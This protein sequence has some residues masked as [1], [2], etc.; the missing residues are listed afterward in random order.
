MAYYGRHVCSRVSAS[1]LWSLG[2]K[3]EL[4]A[5]TLAEYEET[6]LALAQN[7]EKLVSIRKRLWSARTTSSLFDMSKMVRQME[8]LYAGM[9]NRHN[10]GKEHNVPL[11]VDSSGVILS[12]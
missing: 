10:S 8:G 1:L 5:H 4:D 2:L 6:A 9:V 3:D 12:D 7:P 11:A